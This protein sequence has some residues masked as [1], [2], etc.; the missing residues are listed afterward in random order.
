MIHRSTHALAVLALAFALGLVAIPARAQDA[1]AEARAHFARGVELYDEGHHAAALA[2]FQRAYDVSPAPAVLYNIA[3]VHAA[4]GHAVEAIDAFERYL[5]EGGESI[6]PSRRAEVEDELARQ[7]ARIARIAIEANVL[8]AI[9]SIDDVDVGTTPLGDRVRV[10]AGEHVIAARAPGHE[11]ARRRIRVAGG[12]QP[13]VVL[14]LLESGAPRASLRVRSPVPGVEIL[15]D[16]RPLG[17]TPFDASVPIEVGPHRLLARRAG[18]VT[19]ERSFEAEPGAEVPVDVVLAQDPSA[20]EGTRGVLALRL[21]DVEWRGTLDGTAIAAP[22]D[23]IELPVGPHEL[24]LEVARR[25]PVRMRVDVPIASTETVRP[26]L[27]W[28]PEARAEGHA[29]LD[30]QHTAGVIMVVG[31]GLLVAAGGATIAIN[32][33]EWEALDR[34]R[35]AFESACAVN[36]SAPECVALYEPLTIEAYEADFNQRRRLHSGIDIGAAIAIGVGGALAL[37]GTILLISTPSHSDFE[38]SASARVEVGVGPGSVAVRGT[39]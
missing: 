20:P 7:R 25:R 1:R 2:E 4:L 19:F 26:E 22:Q 17:L 6:S 33:E 37:T 10:S 23:E 39:F 24:S 13:S 14:E 27:E 31:G 5:V 28:T 12:E 21:P 32:S 8:G 15:L 36:V 18:Y 3:Q 35:A 9:V 29:A 16:E 30:T 11:A 34:E 38:R